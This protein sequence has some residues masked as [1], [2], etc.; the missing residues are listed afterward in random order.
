MRA[1][2]SLVF[3]LMIS[4]FLPAR[5]LNFSGAWQLSRW[6]FTIDLGITVLMSVWW[7]WVTIICLKLIKANV[8]WIL[9]LSA[10]LLL[11]SITVFHQSRAWHIVG[12]GAL[13][14][15]IIPPLIVLR[16]WPQKITNLK[17]DQRSGTSEA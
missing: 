7:F 9:P 3:Y 12:T 2:W 16:L 6:V 15:A 17:S 8:V 10:P 1:S 14:A 5:I 4:L 13:A 11:A